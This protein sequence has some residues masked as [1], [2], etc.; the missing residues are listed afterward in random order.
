[1]SMRKILMVIFIVMV[2]L[3]ATGTPFGATEDNSTV[4]IKNKT[5]AQQTEENFGEEKTFTIPEEPLDFITQ[6]NWKIAV[7][8]K[9]AFK[10]VVKP[11]AKIYI[12]DVRGNSKEEVVIKAGETKS[13]SIQLQPG[14]LCRF[15]L[16]SGQYKGLFSKK[17]GGSVKATCVYQYIKVT[18]TELDAVGKLSLTVE[19]PK[20]C[21]WIW[22]MPDNQ[23]LYGATIQNT[24]QP[25]S[26]AIG[27][28]D[29]QQYHDFG[30]QLAVPEAV[31]LN[32][33]L[34][35]TS[36]YEEFIVKGTTG[37]K[38]HYRSY[39]Q[40][41]WNF[42]D[43]TPE[44]NGVD[45]E[46]TFRRS[47]TYKVTLTVRNSFGQNIE[48]DWQITVMPFNIINNDI[49]VYPAKG[50]TPLRVHYTAKPKV[51]GQPTQL[52]YLWDFGDGTTSQTISGD[53]VYSKKGDYRIT[54][55][56][57]D[58]YHPNLNLTPWTG[59][60]TVLPPVITVKVQGTPTTGVIP[61]QVRF[62]SEIKVEGGPTDIE[63]QWDFGDDTISNVPNPTHTFAEPGRYKVVLRVRDWKN[64]TSFTSSALI[65][66][67]PP[68]VNS[69]SSLEPLYGPAPLQVHGI[70]Y[71]NVEG[72]PVDL[73]YAWYID[74]R[75]VANTNNLQHNF[76][77]PGVYKVTL[78]INDNMTGHTARAA[79]TWQVTV[80]NPGSRE[81][82]PNP[83]PTLVP[84]LTPH[85]RLDDSN[86]RRPGTPVPTVSPTPVPTQTPDKRRKDGYD[87]R[88]DDH[89]D[90]RNN[91]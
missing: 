46:H 72:Y 83:A 19:G 23:K 64:D 79:H 45:F 66:A 89:W 73:T 68:Q 59:M 2:L 5:I 29:E 14:R 1:M 12:V 38:S 28:D 67:L 61:L 30:F 16:N 41:W 20:N 35:S 50:S 8:K 24:F 26:A 15:Q 88:R 58:D 3:S 76:R 33:Q 42:G 36:G 48:K 51:F 17:Y 90:N 40:S 44:V 27:L 18:A 81:S 21:R 80:N 85:R 9:M 22:S 31:E 39:S 47:G 57:K 13:G 91:K 34:S 53:H 63:Y 62:Y 69:R 6:V 86:D 55:T 84:T 43:G 65:Y 52:K 87:N 25:G 71:A 37:L 82:Q 11:F 54:F 10:T 7:D 32:P 77:N 70:G 49:S 78:F 75:L 74:G 4:Y 56:L 60:V